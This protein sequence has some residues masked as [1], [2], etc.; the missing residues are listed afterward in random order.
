MIKPL[1]SSRTGILAG[2]FDPVHIGHLF[3]VHLAMEAASLD[4]VWFV[5]TH[6]PPHKDKAKVPYFHR[7]NMLQI[8][9]SQE[10][11]FVLMELE[12][13]ARPTYSYETVLSVKHVLGEKPY[14]IL[15]SDEWE[16]LHNWRR[17]DLLIKNAIFIVVPRKPITLARP[18]A[19]A[20]FTDMT[21]INVS[22][23]YIRQRIAQGKPITY[24]VPKTV[25]TYIHENH[26][27]YP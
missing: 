27:Y 26:L 25:E 7:V 10:P 22:S 18:E 2:V 17:Y 8:A 19:E 14:F 3:M 23:T 20:I 12:K 24:L 5:P 16:E 21:P 6:I 15:G 13:E 11:K 9:L 4:K 1:K